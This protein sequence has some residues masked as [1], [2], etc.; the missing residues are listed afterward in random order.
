MADAPDLLAEI[1]SLRP[2][3]GQRQSAL[4]GDRPARKGDKLIQLLQQLVVRGAAEI[5]VAAE[6][7]RKN[8]NAKTG[9]LR[10]KFDVVEIRHGAPMKEL[11]GQNACFAWLFPGFGCVLTGVSAD[12]LNFSRPQNR[13]IWPC[14]SEP[15]SNP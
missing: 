6:T 12:P 2:A 5:V 15:F 11:K 1:V 3:W 9:K 10:V 7:V 4:G 14:G 8:Q 13:L